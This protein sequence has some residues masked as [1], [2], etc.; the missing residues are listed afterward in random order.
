MRRRERASAP[1][2]DTKVCPYCAEVI[3][4]A[5]IRC[6]YCQSDL[7][8]GPGPAIEPSPVIEPH[9]LVEPRP[10]V[11][12]VET[13]TPEP[14][15]GS[16]TDG[17]S[18]SVVL[19]GAAVALVLTLVLSVLAFLAWEE[20]RDLDAAEDAGRTVRA[21]LPDKLTAVLS[22]DFQTFDDAREKALAQLTPS[23]AEEYTD[24]L[25]EIEDRARQQRRS[26][27]ATV[28]AVAVVDAEEDE[29]KTLVF[30][31]RTT[32]TAGSDRQRILQDRLNVTTVRRGD[33]WLIDDISFPTS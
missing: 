8:D 15:G 12:P 33:R 13:R 20:E 16:C 7:T 4:A 18:R 3:K 30:I 22:Y 14:T 19:G 6:R 9:P 11:E 24:T 2:G 29:V 26:Q 25:D 32:S 23:F 21:T 5:A 17:P 31:N 28:V 10:A 27:D 1:G